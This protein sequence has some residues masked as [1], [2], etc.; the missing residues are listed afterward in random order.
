MLG[1]TSHLHVIGDVDAIEKFM[2]LNVVG[3]RIVF[4]NMVPVAELPNKEDD[5]LTQHRIRGEMRE[6]WGT[7]AASAYIYKKETNPMPYRYC[8]AEESEIV[9]SF[10]TD[11]FPP[12]PWLQSISP[13]FPSLLFLLKY[14][15]TEFDRYGVVYCYAGKMNET[16][17]DFYEYYIDRLPKNFIYD[18]MLVLCNH[19]IK[20]LSLEQL[21]SIKSSEYLDQLRKTMGKY[22]EEFELYCMVPYLYD[23]I[24]DYAVSFRDNSLPII[25]RALRKNLTAKKRSI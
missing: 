8:S 24:C 22:I 13:K 17:M 25:E 5:I 16:R 3:D 19:D 23:I 2:R 18:Q 12:I 15:N 10:V 6:V 4:Q 7:N 9:I 11:C 20:S 14:D 21:E 1:Y